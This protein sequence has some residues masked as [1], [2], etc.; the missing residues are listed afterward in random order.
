MFRVPVRQVLGSKRNVP[1]DEKK[2]QSAI[3]ADRRF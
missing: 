1:A 2:R 3:I